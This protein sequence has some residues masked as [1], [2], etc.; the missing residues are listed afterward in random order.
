M[1]D[2][3]PSISVIVPI[4]QTELY[5]KRCIDSILNQ[6][7]ED[8]EVLLVND[9]SQDRSGLICDEY[10]E[11]DNRIRVYH[12]KNEGL[13]ATRQFGIDHSE[14]V[15]SIFC[16]SDDWLDPNMLGVMYE[17]AISESADV[18]ICDM[19]FEYGDHSVVQNQDIKNTDPR[20]ILHNLYY[21]IN[22][23]VCN[24]LIRRSLYEAYNIHYDGK[25]E[26]AE[27]LYA[28]MQLYSHPVKSVYLPY[29]FYHYDRYS[30]S[31]S[32]TRIGDTQKIMS[33]ID[34]FEKRFSKDEL[35]LVKLKCVVIKRLYD[36]KHYKQE[37][38]HN[39]YPEA[40]LFFV[41]EGLRYK[42]IEMLKLGFSFY[43]LRIIGI[44]FVS[45]FQMGIKIKGVL[46][47]LL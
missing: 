23:S 8:I 14:G 39:L 4:Y 29:S 31:E 47:K 13:S 15:Y 11:K 12:K 36:Q 21:P 20:S 19:A 27:D 33:S 7:F 37:D 3:K 32:I 17:S 43:H 34:L 38:L 18:V 1:R 10:A 25:V 22:A 5:L 24:K 46:N 9:G 30:N 45:I 42:N 16:D 35:P 44:L 2:E 40:H 26:Y 6:T 28:M 41:Y